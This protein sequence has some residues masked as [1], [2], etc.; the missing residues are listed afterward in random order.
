ML[1]KSNS[2]IA[3]IYQLAANHYNYDDVTI[4]ELHKPKEDKRDKE[5]PEKS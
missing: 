2:S 5:N 3:A 4:E 1:L